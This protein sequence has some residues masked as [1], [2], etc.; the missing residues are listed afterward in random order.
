MKAL[1]YRTYDWYEWDDFVVASESE[2]KLKNYY[3]ENC[4]TDLPLI[5]ESDNESYK[6]WE[7][8]HYSI[9][10]IKVV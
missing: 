8:S 2:E 3:F 5:P 10:E 7:K 1:F 4:D 6:D 9:V